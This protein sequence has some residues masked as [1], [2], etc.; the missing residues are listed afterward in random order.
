[1]ELGRLPA[2]DEASLASESARE[3][4]PDEF[5]TDPMRRVEPKP[6]PPKAPEPVREVRP[7]LEARAPVVDPRPVEA[8]PVVEP[9]PVVEARPAK[10]E[11]PAV[12]GHITQEIREVRVVV[13]IALTR[14]QFEG[15]APIRVVF[16]VKIVD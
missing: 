11:R 2:L 12:E 16:D 3:E 4:G 15:G 8:R 1:M 14:A 10:P 7:A 9:R 13:P 6:A 5:V